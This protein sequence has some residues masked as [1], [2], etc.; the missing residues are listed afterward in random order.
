VAQGSPPVRRDRQHA[1]QQGLVDDRHA[2]RTIGEHVLVV[3]GLPQGVQRDRNRPDLDRAEEA[4][5][6]RPAVEQEQRNALLG[7]HVELMVKRVADPV[8]ALV[9]VGIRQAL[10]AAFDGHALAA[11]LVQMP[12]HEIG[13]GVEDR[14]NIHS[15]GRLR[16]Q[17]RGRLRA[18]RIDAS[19]ARR[20]RDTGERPV[21]R[22][23]RH[24]FS[25]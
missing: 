10:V 19:L 3:G 1:R 4:A 7:P 8:H 11:A 13:R 24:A 23:G 6:E 12:I 22:R 2:G 20:Q 17:R 21:R 14:R 16:S 9:H 25:R 15:D 5:G 18:A